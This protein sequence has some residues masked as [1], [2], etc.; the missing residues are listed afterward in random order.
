[1]LHSA[2]SCSS[3]PLGQAQSLLNFSLIDIHQ[4]QKERERETGKAKR[5]GEKWIHRMWRQ[6][7]PQ[8]EWGRLVEN[9][10]VATAVEVTHAYTHLHVHTLNHPHTH[11]H[12]HTR[13]H[14]HTDK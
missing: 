14:S 6:T 2:P 1:M 12:T 3:S 13:T 11:T 7:D 10:N 8:T 4:V 9:L 5:E